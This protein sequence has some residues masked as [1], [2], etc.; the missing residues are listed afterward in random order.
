MAVNKY[1]MLETADRNRSI[2][3]EAEE[4]IVGEYIQR[5]TKVSSF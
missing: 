4:F 3:V 1:D 5:K 2:D